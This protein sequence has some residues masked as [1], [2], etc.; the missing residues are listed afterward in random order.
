MS[1][2]YKT[3]ILVLSTM[4]ISLI[5]LVIN[6]QFVDNELISNLLN[7]IAISAMTSGVFSIFSNLIKRDSIEGILEKYFPVISTCKEYGLDNI[8]TR[9]PLDNIKIQEDFI[10]SE[11]IYIVMNDGKSFISN[12]ISLFN[13]RLQKS[14]KTTNI[15]LLDYKQE[16]IMSILTRKNGHENENYYKDKIRG[17][18]NYHLKNAE[19]NETHKIN[20][21]LNSNY[22]TMAMLIMDNYA[23]ISL[24]RVSSGKDIVP[25][26][27]FNKEGS[28]YGKILRD[29]QR[30][31]SNSNVRRVV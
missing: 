17:V 4:L 10:N 6:I 7:T 9:F 18:I 25:H 20:I 21:F 2:K 19:K 14:N 29:V 8:Y 27:V 13:K 22:N 12:N 23:I 28:E 16:D 5:I 24:F 30:L 1:K 11:N 15:V 31:C 26:I 3:I